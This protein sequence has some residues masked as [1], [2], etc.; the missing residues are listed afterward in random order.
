MPVVPREATPSALDMTAG[1]L[2][3]PGGGQGCA[4]T[5]IP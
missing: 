3:G 5:L 2:R 4:G 1:I